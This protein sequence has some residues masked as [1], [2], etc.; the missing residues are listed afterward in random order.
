M[1][2]NQWWKMITKI[3]IIMKCTITML[4]KKNQHSAMDQL[5]F[6]KKTKLLEKDIRFLIRQRVQGELNESSQKVQISSN[7]V[8][9]YQGCVVQDGKYN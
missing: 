6:K 9:K 8:N 3:M 2:H 5:F 1:E 7:T 4:Y